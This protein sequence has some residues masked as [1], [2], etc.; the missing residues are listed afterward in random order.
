MNQAPHRSV[1][2]GL[3]REA[4][5]QAGAAASSGEAPVGALIVDAGS[6][7]ILARAHNECLSS[8][9]PAAH[10]E[11]LALRRAGR[12]LKNYRI[13]G[14]VMVVTLEPCIMCLGAIIQARIS[15]LVFGARDPKAGAI[16]SRLDISE[17]R[18][19]NHRFW[20]VDGVLEEDCSGLLKKFFQDKR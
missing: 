18:W 8:N 9:D 10:A 20:F 19:L 11:I 2:P 1:W 6:K 14:T 3:M 13:P 4:L 17:M 15:G 7:K 12:I 16:I 5:D